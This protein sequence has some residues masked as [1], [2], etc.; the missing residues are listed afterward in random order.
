MSGARVCLADGGVAAGC[1]L[2]LTLGPRQHYR[3]WVIW[4]CPSVRFLDYQKVKHAEREA[5]RGLFGTAEEPAEL[6]SKV[7]RRAARVPSLR[8]LWLTAC[9]SWA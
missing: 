3:Y 7:R 8:R 4:R 5:A 1:E 2:L 9:R 6:A